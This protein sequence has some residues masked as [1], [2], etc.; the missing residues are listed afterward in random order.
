VKSIECAGY[1]YQQNKQD[2][3]DAGGRPKAVSVAV[4][5]AVSVSRR[6]NVSAAS[7]TCAKPCIHMHI[8]IKIGSEPRAESAAQSCHEGHLSKSIKVRFYPMR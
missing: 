5:V 6:R 3:N 1:D 7:M 2:K 4:T 8:R